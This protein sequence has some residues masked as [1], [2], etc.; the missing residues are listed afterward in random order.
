MT[1]DQLYGATPGD[2]IDPMSAPHMANALGAIAM[3]NADEDA[4]PVLIKN[5]PDN[6]VTLPGGYLSAV[7][8]VREAEV[9]ELTGEDEEELARP[10]IGT[11]FAKLIDVLLTRCVTSIGGDPP[12]RV[13]LDDLLI[14]DRD[15]LL[16]GIRVVTYGDTMRLDV[17]CPDCDEKF[18]V[19]YSFTGDVPVRHID[20]L[21]IEIDN[22]VEV[23]LSDH[24]R[25]YRIPLRKGGAA[26]VRLINGGIQRSVY[27]S[28]DAA[29]RTI[30][31]IN[32]L[33]LAQCVQTIKGAPV[34]ADDVRRMN[35]GDRARILKFLGESQPGPQWTQVKHSCPRC[36]REFP[37]VVD[38]PTM[39][40]SL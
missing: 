22:D 27:G 9:R 19:D 23:K 35:S 24:E 10:G 2:Q 18:Q 39:F 30:A 20:G 5:P 7:G 34:D 33:L 25:V 11:N 26:E 36:E 32:T 28:A 38:V 15:M 13:V 14:G 37:L 17:T 40:R 3:G 21:S 16:Q 8:L 6:S 1:V 29:T 12:N 31:E 4:P